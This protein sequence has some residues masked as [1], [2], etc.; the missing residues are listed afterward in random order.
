MP[1]YIWWILAALIVLA[2]VVLFVE[3]VKIGVH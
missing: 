1:K 3:H 2:F